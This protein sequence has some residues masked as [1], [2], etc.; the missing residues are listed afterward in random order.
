M[1][2]RRAVHAADAHPRLPPYLPPQPLPVGFVAGLRDAL[3][4]PVTMLFVFVLGLVAAHAFL[5][6]SVSTACMVKTFEAGGV[7]DGFLPWESSKHWDAYRE[8]DAGATVPRPKLIED[9]AALLR[10]NATKQ[11]AL[12]VGESGTGKSTA[13]RAAVRSLPH[14]KGA[15]Y[16]SAPENMV[17]FHSDLEEAT[18]Y[19]RP[20][21][22]L[23]SFSNWW[24]GQNLN[25]GSSSDM[26]S[27][28]AAPRKAL[29]L[30][31]DAFRM[32]HGRPAVLVIDAADYIAK[33]EPI[34]FA[35]LQD[36][37]KVCADAGSLRIVFVSSE[38]VAL[39][40]MKLSSA[41]SRALPPYEV[42][43]IGDLEA[44]EY[45][46][47]RGVDRPR[48]EEAVRDITGGRF[49]LLLYVASA[50]S[51][52]SIKAIRHELNTRTDTALLELGLTPNHPF[53][54][55]LCT[56]K[57]TSNA[58]I[59]LLSKDKIDALL[60]ANIIAA[61]PDDTYSTHARHVEVFLRDAFGVLAE[62]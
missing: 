7:V 31:A 14:P 42:Q 46:V 6:E 11:Y 27:G 23:A 61:H 16:F 29:K 60:K 22:P 32:K 20:F 25:V 15:I 5:G 53:F 48:A 44:V 2:R 51:V 50:A 57:T 38:G 40:L 17:T 52:K 18:G 43:D 24:G 8:A 45:L 49:A 41:W 35:R 1:A 54:R 12:V 55:E 36:F 10:P 37:A 9:L 21:D 30:A 26:L 39:P 4:T 13:V 56:L 58:A 62:V 28:W 19:F 59:S 47:E 3:G 34:F 33:Q